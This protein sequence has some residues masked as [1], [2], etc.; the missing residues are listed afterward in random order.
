MTYGKKK[1]M[2]ALASSLQQSDAHEDL[3]GP[4]PAGEAMTYG[5]KK[6]MRAPAS[7][8]Q[9]LQPSKGRMTVM[10]SKPKQDSLIAFEHQEGVAQHAKTGEKVMRRERNDLPDSLQDEI[11]DEHGDMATVTS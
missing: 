6:T 10:L 5:K 2:K 9:L 11:M 8:L 1:T 3:Q 4:M 7:A